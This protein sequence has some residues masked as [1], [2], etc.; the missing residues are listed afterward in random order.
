MY[1]LDGSGVRVA[2]VD[3]GVDFSNPDLRDSLARDPVTN[4][5][6]M[7]D[8]D[9]QGIVLTNATFVAT[10]QDDGT[11]A[12]HAGALPEWAT[13]SVHVMPNG[14]FLDV[15]QDGLG[16]ELQVYNSFFPKAGP[17][18]GPIFNA[19]ID[20]DMKIGN[21]PRDYIKSK[22]GVYRLGVIYQ[23][24][25]E[26]PLTGLQVVPVL[27]V[28]SIDAG[29]YDTIVPDL[30][31][32]WKDY[33]RNSLP[34]G[35]D[36]EYDFDFTDETAVTLGSGN[37]ILV[38]D[39]DGDGTGDYSVGTLGAYVID[40][41]GVT[42]SS[43]TGE[44]A[45]IAETRVLPPLDPG[46][47]FFGI[48]TDLQGHGTSSAA[49]ISS[50]GTV[51]YGI[52]D[53]AK[54]FTITGAAPGAEIVP[55]KALWYGNTPHAWLWS[56]GFSLGDDG[57]W[58]Y[59]AA[60]RADIV[61][62]S[63]GIPQFPTTLEAP[64]S[65]SASMLLSY[66]SSPRSASPDYP[67][68]L[69]VASAGNAGHGYGTLSSPGASPFAVTVGATTNNVFVGYGAFD[70]QPRFGNTTSAHGHLVDFSSRGPGTIA[71]PKPDIIAMG[72]HAFV[73]SSL[74]QAPDDD[75]D[76]HGE[77]LL[78]GGTSMSAPIVA[79]VA[80]VVMEA[81]RE[82]DAYAAADPHRLKSILLSTASDTGN[83]AFSQGAGAVNATAAVE[84]VKDKHG[85]F[86]VTND[87]THKNIL[88]VI[89]SPLELV[90]ATALGLKKLAL[91]TQDH[92][93]TSWYGG[94]L[95][96]GEYSSTT[97][98][99]ENPSEE[100][101]AIYVDA[102]NLQLIST[103]SYMGETVP[104]QKDP[105]LGGEDVFAPN[106]VRIDDIGSHLTLAS[107][108]ERST[109]PPESS[110]M[111]LSVNFE[112]GQFMNMTANDD[113]YASDLRLASL[114]LYDWID[115][116]NDTRIE[117]SELSL[118]SRAGS[119][120]TVQEIRISD[121]A[122]QFEGVPIAGV[123]PVPTRYSYWEGDTGKDTTPIKYDLT[124]SYYV[125]ATWD[126][127]WLDRDQIVV[128]PHSTASVRAT[129]YASHESMPGV[130]QGFVRFEGDRQSTTVP[131]SYSVKVPVNVGQ[132]ATR[133][134]M[135]G[136]LY[137][138]GKVRG[139]FDVVSTYMDGDWNQHHF[140]VDDDSVSAALIDVS[141]ESPDTSVSIFV[142]DPDGSISAS[143]APPGAFGM[144]GWPSSDWLGTTD[145]SQGGGFF[146][147]TGRNETSSLVVTPINE[148]GTYGIMTH[149]TI[150][151]GSTLSENMSIDVK[152]H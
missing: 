132:T 80:A 100:E 84:F 33:T 6:I 74:M 63:W 136:A 112:L 77:F 129:I 34:L 93:H 126:A 79:G 16:T 60:P 142:V 38:Y 18:M 151:G 13:S 58:R 96:L 76:A 69:F 40:V 47:E 98:T 61:S 137:S 1:D 27:V 147:V 2:I 81:I 116:N 10:I 67:G 72:A 21:S 24:A 78:F 25:L 15:D 97:F 114:Y 30:S 144:A 109:I 22:S 11:I 134:G 127:V 59:S 92:A 115:Q 41:Y 148:A 95:D 85:S 99:V 12:E 141:W 139:A 53:S 73:P 48:M 20:D 120:G 130:H 70:G 86:I 149:A 111:V 23:G 128:P 5:P 125:P 83:D 42:G 146:P 32:S 50:D 55:V 123:Y 150:F 28:D 17:G 49:T 71:D 54:T 140:D 82:A 31:T 7:L 43:Y 14:V 3:T 57:M 117:S 62:N 145:F 46:G 124:A 118:I 143:S 122:L 39:S 88:D 68:T 108:F 51:E 64:G 91:P 119:W 52:Y 121:P 19:T 104:H 65:D 110:L 35:E 56:S 8:A 37:E 131:V 113:M 90:N 138:P 89:L 94:R 107:Y 29:V 4:H 135:H 45:G 152:L 133:D 75:D 102:S 26:G 9:A 101:L 36:P 103:S 106:Y 44:P 87:A 105:K 66:L